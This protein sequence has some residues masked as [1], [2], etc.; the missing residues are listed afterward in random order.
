M[1]TSSVISNG[2]KSSVVPEQGVFK[3]PFVPEQSETKTARPVKTC[4]IFVDFSRQNSPQPTRN[5][6][7]FSTPEAIRTIPDS[8]SELKGT[9]PQP[10]SIPLVYTT[11]EDIRAIR[12]ALQLPNPISPLNNTPTEPVSEENYEIPY[13]EIL[14]VIV[15]SIS[16]RIDEATDMTANEQR[17]LNELLQSYKNVFSENGPPAFHIE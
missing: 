2:T 10:T 8:I 6:S 1:K 5:S 13:F 9:P 7:V 17:Q 11:P 12:K 14:S 3:K 16:V 4:S 15:F